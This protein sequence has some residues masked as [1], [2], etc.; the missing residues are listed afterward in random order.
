MKKILFI[1]IPSILILFQNSCSRQPEIPV[2]IGRLEKCLFT[3]PVDSVAERIPSLTKQYGALLEKLSFEI[4]I[5]MPDHPNY[6]EELTE[7]I[8]H[9]DMVMTYE[10][11]VAAFP[12][13]NE[14]ESGLGKAFFNYSKK[15]PN[16]AIP[17][18]Y[19]LISGFNNKWIVTDEILAIA[20]D[21]YLG[22]DEEIYFWLALPNYERRLRDKKFIVPQAMN[23]WISTE[24]PFVNETNDVLNNILYQGKLMYA[25]HKILPHT[26]DSLLFGFTP[27]QMRWCQNNTAQMWT[28]LVENQLLF[29]SDQFTINKLIGHTPFTSTFTRESPG[30]A[31]V[32]LGFK[33]IESFM[34]HEKISLEE[35]MLMEDYQQILQKARFKPRR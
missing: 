22:V 28:F 26:P 13:L 12:D 20:I 3:I 27:D 23:A 18:I 31:V 24:F 15:F 21:Q 25:L 8:T 1:L 30:R 10:K 6:A 34:K 33:I 9:P 7:F 16:R 14:I 19:T 11:V 5:A 29:V 4:N 32:W 35:L 2:N 17:S